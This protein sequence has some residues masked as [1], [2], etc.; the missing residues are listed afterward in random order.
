VD[1]TRVS[2]LTTISTFIDSDVPCRTW[3]AAACVLATVL[4]GSASPTAPSS[5]ATRMNASGD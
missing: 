4:T 3:L 2:R 5:M 1:E